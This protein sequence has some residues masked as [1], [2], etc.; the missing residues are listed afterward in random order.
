M[1]CCLYST[2]LLSEEMLNCLSIKPLTNIFL[3]IW[4]YKYSY[5]YQE[6]EFVNVVYKYILNHILSSM[7]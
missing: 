2:Y 4:E 5:F 3:I 7:C 1:T 6:N